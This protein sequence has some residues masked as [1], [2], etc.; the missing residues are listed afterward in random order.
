[1]SEAF[2]H[3]RLHGVSGPKLEAAFRSA[4]RAGKRARSE[5]AIGRNPVSISSVAV[6]LAQDALGDL[7][8]VRALVIGAGEM[9]GL[10]VEA[11]CERGV[12]APVI[13]NRTLATA[14]ELAGRWG[15]QALPLERLDEALAQADLVVACSGAPFVIV[16]PALLCHALKRE[17]EFPLVFIDIAVPRNVSPEV[18]RLPGVRYYDIDDLQAAQDEGRVGREGA[19]P[20]VEAIIAQELAAYREWERQQQVA[21]IIASLY[22]RAEA[23]RQAEIERSLRR[24]PDAGPAERERLEALTSAIVNRLLYQATTTLKA[25]AGQE[26]AAEYIALLQTLFSLEGV[27]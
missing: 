6:H 22:A 20:Q 27:G 14:R 7:H 9:A 17:R 12:E 15:G 16:T 19:I 11:L 5:T 10:A 3:A 1:V 21:P 8:R 26:Q 24:W 4:I 23:I 13:V 25:E 18:T 2:E